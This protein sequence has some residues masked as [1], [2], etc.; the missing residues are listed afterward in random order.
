MLFCFRYR[1]LQEGVLNFRAYL[2]V[3]NL[4][5]G[6]CI[7]I[8]DEDDDDEATRR[9]LDEE[10]T[11]ILF[12]YANNSGFLPSNVTSPTPQQVVSAFRNDIMAGCK[13]TTQAGMLQMHMAANLLGCPINSW[14]PDQADSAAFAVERHLTHRCVLPFDSRFEKN[15]SVNILWTVPCQGSTNFGHFVPVVR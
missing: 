5:K 10:G 15:Q 12:L 2:E 4:V 7:L 11:N 14:L 13:S 9:R 6:H 1:I 8:D 3:D